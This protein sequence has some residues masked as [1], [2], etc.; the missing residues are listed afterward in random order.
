[1]QLVK[2]SHEILF[3]T[4]NSLEMI[5]A[6]GRTCYKS[7]AKITKGSAEKFVR[8]RMKGGHNSIIEHV[9]ITVRFICDRGVT[10]EL[11]R[12]RL[13]AYSQECVSG[14]T[15]VRKNKTIKQLFDR[16]SNPYGKTHN[17]IISLRSCDE[18]GCII[19][20]K[21]QSVFY[22]GIAPVYEVCTSLGYKIKTTLNHKFQ[23]SDMS[24]VRLNTLS[25]GDSI[26]INGRPCLLTI[27][28]TVLKD[29]YLIQGYDPQ[30][31]ALAF[32]APYRTI[33]R[34]L[35]HMG[36]FKK[37]LNDKDKEKY[38]K[39]H[40]SISYEKMRQTIQEQYDN[41]R[42]VWN[43][44]LK[45]QDHPSVKAQAESLRQNHHTNGLREN[46]SNWKED[47][48]SI[49]GG[50]SRTHREHPLKEK[51]DLCG[52]TAVER[53]HIDGNPVN[54]T[55]ANI[56]HLC[57]DCHKKLHVGW[58]VGMRSHK[59]TIIGINYVG[60]EPVY[61]LEMKA[62]YHNYVANGF[63]I[64]NST[65][66]CNYN[67]MEMKFII[68]GDFVLDEEDLALLQLIERHYNK[69]LDTKH[70]TPQQARYFLPNGLKTEIVMTANLREIRHILNLRCSKAAHPQMRE[71][72]LPLL[73][74]LHTRIP[75]L[76]DDLY[77]KYSIAKE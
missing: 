39:N 23:L 61:D 45:E 6:A 60:E 14:D 38:N 16:S 68:P 35:K 29:L 59:D 55:P 51:C 37:H 70:R 46:N 32:N 24:F 47:D 33:L 43:K 58:W 11:V 15:L 3:I 27:S 8:S 75:V 7:E 50:Y 26:M 52:A 12:H 10:H 34:K 9:N 4:P 67:K 53:H 40:T 63:V 41:G 73:E 65:R 64:H 49:H 62:P 20:N 44:G 21:M 77:T 1:M 71:L 19:R 18:K 17:K 72:M 57:I 22:K 66:Y 54:V 48:I 56:F 69:C 31:I 74:E 2:P 36:I 13:A 5:E 28:D 30:K 76:F 42:M 25:V